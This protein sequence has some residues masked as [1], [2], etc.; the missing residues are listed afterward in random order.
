MDCENDQ[1]DSVGVISTMLE[2][3]PTAKSEWEARGR[4]EEDQ[5]V[6]PATL[7]RRRNEMLLT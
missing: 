1:D 6:A 7:D 5:N 2:E 3:V 4:A